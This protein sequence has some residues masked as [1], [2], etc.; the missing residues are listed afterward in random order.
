[1]IGPDVN[2]TGAVRHAQ[3]HPASDGEDKGP[4]QSAGRVDKARSVRHRSFTSM[5]SMPKTG[6]HSAVKSADRVLDLF[7]LLSGW[8]HEMSHNEIAVALAIPKSSLT[9]LLKNMVARGYIDFSAVSS[10]YRLGEAFIR[11]AQRTG[12][13]RTLL[14]LAAPILEELT[15]QTRESSTLNQL[16][17]DQTEVIAT[18]SSPL[19]LVSH[20]D[21]GDVGPLYALSGGKAI[22]AAMPD[23]LI[24]DYLARVAF[25][26]I[27]PKTISTAAQLRREIAQVR[28]H[29]VAYSLE[30]FTPGISGIGVAI[31][32]ESGF[33]LGS[34]TLAIPTARFTQE[35]KQRGIRLLKSAAERIRRHYLPHA[36]TEIARSDAAPRQSPA[37]KPKPHSDEP[38]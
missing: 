3:A 12:Q 36:T 28:K 10:G 22:L 30:E 20:M 27:T 8:G 34:L 5:N 38:A 16:R 24:E 13:T 14:T 23:P 26:S 21:V 19:P 18:V 29:G 9:Q 4:A 17:G 15:E 7:E 1:M 11:I 2:P 33:P 31:L 25:E 35:L 32:S 6:S 37:T